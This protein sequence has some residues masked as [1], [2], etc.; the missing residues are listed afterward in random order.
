MEGAYRTDLQKDCRR[1]KYGFVLIKASLDCPLACMSVVSLDFDCFALLRLSPCS[2]IVITRLT[3]LA[4]P[5]SNAAAILEIICDDSRC[6][7]F[8]VSHNTFRVQK[9]AL[10]KPSARTSGSLH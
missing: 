8:N 3:F 7:A 4:L 2:F 10:L 6:G 5:V 1:C 9:A